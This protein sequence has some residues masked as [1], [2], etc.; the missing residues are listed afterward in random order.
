MKLK[1]TLLFSILSI[2]IFAQ[3]N[4]GIGLVTIKFDDKT[5]LP[6]YT[7]INDKEPVKTIRFFNDKSI[8]SWNIKDLK[9]QQK[10]LKPEILWLDYNYFVFRCEEKENNWF[11][12]IVDNESGKSLWIKKSKSTLFRNWEKFLQDM[13]S[14]QRKSKTD[15]IYKLPNKNSGAIRYS[16][17][18]CFQVRSMK[19]DWIEVFTSECDDVKSQLKSGWIKWKDGNNLLIEYFPTS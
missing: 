6:F 10:W 11:K 18:D 13:F 15:K 1:L 19:G 12:I 2:S 4:L 5:V 16:A 17:E 7:S 9:N 14:V 8:N 3:T